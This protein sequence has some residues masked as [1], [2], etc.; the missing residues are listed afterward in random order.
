MPKYLVSIILRTEFMQQ[1]HIYGHNIAPVLHPR[2]LPNDWIYAT[3]ILQ[4]K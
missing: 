1:W 2:N 4:T 3:E